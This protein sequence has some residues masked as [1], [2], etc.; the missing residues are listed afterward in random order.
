MVAEDERIDAAR[1]CNKDLLL[2]VVVL[3][4]A[5]PPPAEMFLSVVASLPKRRAEGITVVVDC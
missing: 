4:L 2:P 3:R 5:A 1:G